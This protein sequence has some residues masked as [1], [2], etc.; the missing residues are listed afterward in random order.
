MSLFR[1]NVVAC[2]PKQES[3]VTPAIDVLVDT[4]WN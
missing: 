4:A 2:N 3:Q 1:V